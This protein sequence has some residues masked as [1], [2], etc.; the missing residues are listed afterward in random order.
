MFNELN[1]SYN[2]FVKKNK[3]KSIIIILFAIA[4]MFLEILSISILVPLVSILTLGIETVKDSIFEKF[5]FN[6][7]ANLIL[8]NVYNF[9][10]FVFAVFIFKNIFF[11]YVTYYQLKYFENQNQ[12]LSNNL[13]NNYLKKNYIFFLNQNIAETLRNMR[14]EVGSTIL[15]YRSLI[16]LVSEGLIIF[17]LVILLM[18]TNF[19][20]TLLISL[21]FLPIIYLFNFYTK[22]KIQN[23]GTERVELDGSVNKSIIQGI[24]S[25]KEIKLANK[26]EIFLSDFKKIIN[27][28]KFNNLTINFIGSI[29]R[30]IL[31]ILI[32]G[33]ILVSIILLEY[34]DISK[35]ETITILTIFT[36][37]SIRM[38]PS[39]N[40]IIVHF[41]QLRFRKPS[42]SLINN[43]LKNQSSKKQAFKSQ[44]ANKK[45]FINNIQIKDLSFG[46]NKKLI[47]NKINLELK[48]N[49]VLGVIGET[50]SG[51]STFLDLLTGLFD[52][53]NGSILINGI[54]VKEL[55]REWQN[56]IAYV[57]QK[58][59]LMDE[60][61]EKNISFELKSDLINKEKLQNCISESE[62]KEFIDQLELKEKTVIGENAIKLS[63]GQIQ[64]VALARALYM[65]KQ[66]LILDEA[67]SAL[68]EK[69]E[70]KIINKI[71]KDI[72]NKILIIVS[73]NKS[74][75][76]FCTKKLIINQN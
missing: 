1:I 18:Y 46:Y 5:Y 71:L 10:F 57:S 20:I 8:F 27:K 53:S 28:I 41:Q 25:I 15:Y 47:L 56:Q 40:R 54:N 49:D 36:L 37:S 17:G 7:F 51:K 22:N 66:I 30:A 74:I 52:P 59:Y 55:K 23:L 65:D 67:T 45:I 76:K 29:P 19:K 61:I 35:N 9:I 33:L 70:E 42:L 14:N 39:I 50:G 21:I 12:N 63:G 3:I 72:N 64:R 62:L 2:L 44:E 38:L 26:E 58:I 24:K 48:P 34:L 60:T 75:I 32:V 11:L 69:T 4:L 73:H 16:G 13:F 43:Q 6:E 68:D 31:E